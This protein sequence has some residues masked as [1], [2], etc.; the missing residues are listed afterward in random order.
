MNVRRMIHI[1]VNPTGTLTNENDPEKN[2]VVVAIAADV[3]KL[4]L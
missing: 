1:F 2:A 3:S 4:F